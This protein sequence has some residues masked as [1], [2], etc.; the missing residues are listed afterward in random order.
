MLTYIVFF[1]VWMIAQV[2]ILYLYYP[3]Y[4]NVK[5]TIINERASFLLFVYG[6]TNNQDF[7]KLFKEEIPTYLSDKTLVFT[8]IIITGL[9]GV[10]FILPIFGET[11]SN[12]LMIPFLII[13][14][15]FNLSLIKFYDMRPIK[16]EKQ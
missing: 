8:P 1:V 7:R 13:P 6:M 9:I 5:G 14:F 3:T 2:S 15:V 4:K 10:F 12:F 11:N 16:Q